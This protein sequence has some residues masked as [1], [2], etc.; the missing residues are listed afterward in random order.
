VA[1]N[2]HPDLS[3]PVMEADTNIQPDSTREQAN[4]AVESIDR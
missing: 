3:K 4:M 1:S 2:D